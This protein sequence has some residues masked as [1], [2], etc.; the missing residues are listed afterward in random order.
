VFQK[1]PF[2]DIYQTGFD[3]KFVYGIFSGTEKYII[4]FSSLCYVAGKMHD[5][6]INVLATSNKFPRN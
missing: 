3:A 2:I 6:A 4:L 1:E 5:L